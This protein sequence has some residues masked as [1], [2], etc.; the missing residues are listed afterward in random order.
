MGNAFVEGIS[1]GS[2][3]DSRPRGSSWKVY[4]S[5]AIQGRD[6]A[7]YHVPSLALQPRRRNGAGNTFS[8]IQRF[9]TGSAMS[10]GA[11]KREAL[12]EFLAREKR[13]RFRK[14][15]PDPPADAKESRRPEPWVA[16]RGVADFIAGKRIRTAP[17]SMPK[18]EQQQ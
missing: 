13:P 11:S 4:F 8:K 10:R 7:E 9:P 6:W 12:P 15:R 2:C 17:V 16:R 18:L 14:S 3:T 1:P 5:R